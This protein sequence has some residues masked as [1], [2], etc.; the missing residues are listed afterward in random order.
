M[1][2]ELSPSIQLVNLISLYLCPGAR[3]A[4]ALTV[5]NTSITLI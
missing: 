3:D 5:E 4:A 2:Y 1:R